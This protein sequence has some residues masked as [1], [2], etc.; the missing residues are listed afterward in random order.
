MPP[1]TTQLTIGPLI[2]GGHFGNVFEAQCVVNGKVAVKLLKQKPGES[3]GDWA[4]RSSELLHEAIKLKTAKHPNVVEVLQVVKDTNGVVHLVSEH[5]DGGSIESEYH[6]GPM[7]LTKVRKIVTDVARGLECIHSRQMI[8]R[9]IKPGNILSHKGVY[10]IGDFGL[11]SDRLLVGY[12]SAAGY[13]NHLAPEV[14]GTSPTSP[15]VTSAKT[16]VWALG[17]TVYRLLNGHGHY[18]DAF[19][20][21]TA[22]E[23]QAMLVAGDF[24]SKLTWLPHVPDAWRKFVRK[25]MHDNS[26]QRFQTAHGLSQALARLSVTPAWDCQYKFDRIVWTRSTGGRTIAVTWQIHSPRRHQWYAMRTGG[27]KRSACIGGEVGKIVSMSAARSG[28]EQF[29]ATAV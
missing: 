7:S 26:G 23:M 27:G 8:H 19:G 28:L 17:M 14:F 4:L 16:D 25:A 24:S 22:V 29:F 10:K 11:V 18:Q 9:D 15:G 1:Y 2:G 12:G 21:K 6:S 13:V 5:C 3:P 20:L